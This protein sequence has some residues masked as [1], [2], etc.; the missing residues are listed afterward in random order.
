MKNQSIELKIVAELSRFE[1]LELV[2]SSNEWEEQLMGKIYTSNSKKMQSPISYKLLLFVGLF[3]LFNIS[4]FLTQIET[5][6]EN[7]N[8]R[9]DLYNSVSEQFLITPTLSNK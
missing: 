6:S 8:S 1:K 7:V 4:F 5:N 2:H 9:S 3:L